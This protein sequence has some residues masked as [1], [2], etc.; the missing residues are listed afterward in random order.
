MAECLNKAS[1]ALTEVDIDEKIREHRTE[2]FLRFLALQ[3]E[4]DLN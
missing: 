3:H 2:E 4:I 1:V